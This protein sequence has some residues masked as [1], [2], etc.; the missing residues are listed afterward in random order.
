MGER[1]NI[2]SLSG[3]GF[4]GLYSATLLT[5]L[6]DAAGTPLA[7]C[8]DLLAG[9]SVG[10]IIALG[11]AA[12]KPVAKI[13]EAIASNGIAIF[14]DR[15]SPSGGIGSALDFWRSFRKPKYQ[16]DA[17]RSVI[18]SLVGA[19]TKIGDLPHR[20]IVPAVNLTK[21]LPQLFKTPH[22]PSFKTDLHLRVV[23]VALATAAAPTYFPI[24]EIDDALFADGGL[25]A[26]S[27]DLLA[28]HEAEH[29]LG[30]RIDDIHL[31]SIG[32]TTAQFSFAH[33]HG[34]QLGIWGWSRDQRLVNVII[35]SQQ[36]S[37]NYMM[38]HRLADR[39]IRLDAIQSK[40]QERHLA[41][42]IAT[43]AA[44]KTIRGLASAT[45][46]SSINI[47]LLQHFLAHRAPPPA[48]HHKV[49]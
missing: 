1:F 9:T 21:G 27:P 3:G 24:A 33:A 20:V 5:G 15:P 8:F 41:L 29:F 28:V 25:Y 47:P 34:R 16:A 17:L 4:L 22:H 2:L 48:F 49:R 7:R 40:E 46:Q 18:E 45:L 30:Q 23:D 14:S 42:D 26:N 38:C 13:E 6:E 35:A 19:K 32:T 31:L 36:H 39:Y 44:Q 43:E 10:G 11:L 12:E 37:V